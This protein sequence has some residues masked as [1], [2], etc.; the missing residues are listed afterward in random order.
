MTGDCLPVLFCNETGTVVAAAHAGWRG[1]LN[2]I[3]EATVEK[4][5]EP[6]S[7]LLAWFGPA[8]TQKHY[9]LG[10][11]VYQAFRDHSPEAQAAFTQKQTKFHGDLYL[12]AKQRLTKIGL[13]KIYGEENCTYS[14]PHKFYSYRRD[15]LTGRMASLIWITT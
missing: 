3:L 12:L 8:I 7:K 5:N 11:E 4:M 2:G 6:P 13:D 14:Q 10:A 1:L 9:E 15:G